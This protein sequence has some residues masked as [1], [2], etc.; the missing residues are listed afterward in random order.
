M[1]LVQRQWSRAHW[2]CLPADVLKPGIRSLTASALLEVSWNRAAEE[3]YV[4]VRDR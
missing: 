3:E 2:I 1:T 4:D